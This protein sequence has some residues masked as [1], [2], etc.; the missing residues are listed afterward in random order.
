VCCDTFSSHKKEG[1]EKGTKKRVGRVLHLAMIWALT[2][3]VA[4]M[5]I[6]WFVYYYRGFLPKTKKPHRIYREEHFY[7]DYHQP[8]YSEPPPPIIY[9]QGNGVPQQQQQQ[10]QQPQANRPPVKRNG[11]TLTRSVAQQTMIQQQQMQ[12]QMQQQ[13]QQSVLTKQFI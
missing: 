10:Q 5:M 4:Y 12:M 3:I 11:A 13:P 6:M 7:E 8:Q 2:S 1:K 9:R